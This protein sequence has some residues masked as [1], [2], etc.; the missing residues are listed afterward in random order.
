MFAARIL[1]AADGSHTSIRALEYARG[2]IHGAGLS[3]AVIHVVSG[4]STHP[5]SLDD[6][7]HTESPEERGLRLLNEACHIL[8]LEE[9]EVERYLRSGHP[10][11]QIVQAAREFQADM[12]IMGSRGRFGMKGSLGSVS[13]AVVADAPCSV[14][15]VKDQIRHTTGAG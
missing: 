14:L 12:I 4:E 13:Q 5:E 8:G 7:G 6:P 1:V 15:V 11:E 2:V 9:E 10:A 3:V